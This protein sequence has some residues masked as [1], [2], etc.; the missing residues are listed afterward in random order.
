MKRIKHRQQSLS[1]CLEQVIVNHIGPNYR[2]FYLLARQWE[3]LVGMD[4]AAHVT[5]AWFRKD[6]LWLYVDS[7][8]WMQE[9]SFAKASL[10]PKVNDCLESIIIKDIRCLQHPQESRLV[11]E[12]ITIPNRAINRKEEQSFRQMTE[13][14][15]D[16]KCG[17][18]LFKLWQA[19][20]TK[21]R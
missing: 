14:I 6:T 17:Q 5:P 15:P 10:I 7:S 21:G 11:P 16:P 18:A 8:V 9:I 20:Q 12:K 13:N 19:F 3:S 2:Q 1:Q 4:I